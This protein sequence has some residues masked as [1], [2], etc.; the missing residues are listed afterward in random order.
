MCLGLGR[1]SCR[2]LR[3][4]R[5]MHWRSTESFNFTNLSQLR[6]KTASTVNFQFT[7][8]T[9]TQFY[10]NFKNRSKSSPT[11]LAENSTRT[12]ELRWEDYEARPV[13]PISRPHITPPA[14]FRMTGQC[15]TFPF[16][17]AYTSLQR[18]P[19]KSSVHPRDLWPTFQGAQNTSPNQTS[20]LLSFHL[21]HSL[22][23]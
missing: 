23:N 4:N 12:Q 19:Q 18:L 1:D 8:V 7:N 17:T 20:A 13:F 2:W 21:V 6:G 16:R 9:Q 10:C 11:S 15:C 22:R 5:Y 3:E 14:P